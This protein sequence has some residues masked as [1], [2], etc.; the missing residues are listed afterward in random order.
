MGISPQI[1]YA[2]ERALARARETAAAADKQQEALG[3]VTLQGQAWADECDSLEAA[4]D[5]LRSLE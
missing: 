3:M 4:V 2:V 5:V 1:R